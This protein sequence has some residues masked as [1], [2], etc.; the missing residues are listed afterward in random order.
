[1]EGENQEHVDKELEVVAHLAGFETQ[2]NLHLAGLS[3]DP[4]VHLR[5]NKDT[6]ATLWED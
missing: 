2:F 6:S 1:M 3:T 4:H 5:D